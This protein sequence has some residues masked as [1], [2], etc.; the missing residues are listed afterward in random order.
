MQEYKI[1][2]MMRIHAVCVTSGATELCLPVQ[3]CG[4]PGFSIFVSNQS[5]ELHYL[6]DD[7]NHLRIEARR[8]CFKDV[9][10][11]IHYVEFCH[12]RTVDCHNQDT[13]ID[14]EISIQRSTTIEVK[15]GINNNYYY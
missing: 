11:S 3:G 9:T 14:S 15:T 1:Y 5:Q 4:E 10:R 8:I 2:F 12:K 13:N 6:G 7:T